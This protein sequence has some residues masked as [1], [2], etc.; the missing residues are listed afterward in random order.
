METI[1][2]TALGWG[3]FFQSQLTPMLSSFEFG[4]IATEHKTNYIVRSV[5]GIYIAEITGKLMYTAESE[6]ALPKVGDWVAFTLMDEGKAIIHHVLQ[7]KTCLSRKAVGKK[8]TEQVIATNLD[9]LFI[10]Q[11]LD[12]NFNISRAERYVAALQP[13]IEPVIVLNKS[14]FCSDVAEKVA[15]V[16][17][18]LP[19]IQ[20]I[21]TSAISNQ[22]EALRNFI[23]EGKTFAFVGSSGVGKSS[24]INSLVA[25]D[26]MKTSEVREKDSK[27]RHT[28]TRRE[29]VCLAGGGILIDTPG[30]REFAPWGDDENFTVGFSDIE[31]YASSC[32][33]ADCAHMHEDNCAVKDAVANGE[34]ESQHYNNYLKL[35]REFSWQQSLSDPELAQER[36]KKNKAQQRAANKIFRKKPDA[37]H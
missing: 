6:A 27:G 20:V 10:V 33:Y 24:L 13:G 30:M 25:S 28:T 3:D 9:V 18:R 17:Q 14:D 12:D 2:L 26:L 16:Q 34:I 5:S 37:P 15:T 35:K 29:M 4:R 7:R 32:K 22:L 8:I 19:G 31:T 11:S 1:S 23:T 21:A 36:K